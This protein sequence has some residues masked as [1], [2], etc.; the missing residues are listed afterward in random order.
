MKLLWR[1]W[2]FLCRLWIILDADMSP[3]A[4]RISI[5]FSILNGLFV[6]GNDKFIYERPD[7]I[8]PHLPF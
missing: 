6:M 1:S 7:P 4:A 3:A 5:E 8:A 2:R